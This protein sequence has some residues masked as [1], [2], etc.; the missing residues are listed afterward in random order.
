MNVSFYTTSDPNYVV[1]KT[2][3]L[4]A[5]FTCNLKDSTSVEN[6]VILVTSASNPSGYNYMYIQEFG[7]YYYITD[8]VSVRNGLWA[9]SGHVDV[10]Y[11]YRTSIKACSAIIKRQEKQFNM[12]LDDPEFKT[13]NNSQIVCKLLTGA[14]GPLSKDMKYVLVVAGG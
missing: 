3:T 10:L 9:I 6:P 7:R 12:Y 14:S 8:V 1:N 4:Q 13:Y 5:S 11:T 2:I